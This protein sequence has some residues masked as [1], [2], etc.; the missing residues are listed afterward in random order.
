[1]HLHAAEHV[2]ALTGPVAGDPVPLAERGG[3]TVV[4]GEALLVEP[5]LELGGE[6]LG[7]EPSHLVSEPQRLG[8]PLEVHQT[9]P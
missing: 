3:E 7:E 1:V 4:V 6:V 2:E 5:V 8:I 9:L